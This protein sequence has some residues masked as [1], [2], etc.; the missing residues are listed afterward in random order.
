MHPR[1]SILESQQQKTIEEMIDGDARM[2]WANGRWVFKKQRV[3]ERI[4]TL[5]PKATSLKST[6]NTSRLSPPSPRAPAP[7]TEHVHSDPRAITAA[8]RLR[9][10][11]SRSRRKFTPSTT[12]Q[13]STRNVST[14]PKKGAIRTSTHMI[15]AVPKGPDPLRPA[16]T[17]SLS[18]DGQKSTAY[19]APTKRAATAT[20]TAK[21]SYRATTL[22][23]VL[24][25]AALP[26]VTPTSYVSSF[27]DSNRS[28][29]A[30]AELAPTRAPI[31]FR[32]FA[33]KLFSNP[34]PQLETAQIQPRP[35]ALWT[36]HILHSQLAH[37]RTTWAHQRRLQLLHHLL[38]PNHSHY[39]LSNPNP[40]SN[41]AGRLLQ[42]SSSPPTLSSLACLS[43]QTQVQLPSSSTSFYNL[44]WSAYQKLYNTG[45]S[46][47]TLSKAK[48]LF[49]ACG[50]EMFCK[51]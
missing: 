35:S 40:N 19:Q 11:R 7:Q 47:K 37:L 9:R 6:F 42:P 50:R 5:A 34:V 39:P 20:I 3:F 23:R 30:R 46:G 45:V 27:F 25:K 51:E 44:S 32:S 15:E 14:P 17:K 21:Q 31:S 18:A 1:S 4:A 43:P 16:L 28:H 10:A 26:P 36:T 13:S 2:V 29:L 38:H 49:K 12:A 24:S 41:R 48:K 33:P 8:R 22:T